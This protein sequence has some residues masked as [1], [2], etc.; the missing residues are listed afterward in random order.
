M[1]VKLSKL[2]QISSLDLHVKGKQKLLKMNL[3][4]PD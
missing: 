2:S 4:K 1:K 3:R